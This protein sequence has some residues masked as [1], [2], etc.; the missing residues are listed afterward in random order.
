[1]TV[2]VDL[3]D[4]SQFVERVEKRTTEFV[5]I[6]VENVAKLNSPVDTGFYRNNIRRD[7]GEN[8]VTANADYSAAIEYG[9]SGTQ[10]P[11]NPVMRSAARKVQGDVPRLFKRAFRNV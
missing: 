5:L 1:M 4:Y 11:P 2:K 10:R 3:P 6:E 9:V 7:I 8:S